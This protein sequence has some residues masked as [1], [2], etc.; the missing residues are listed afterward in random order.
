MI[1]DFEQEKLRRSDQEEACLDLL[2]GLLDPFL[3][4]EKADRESL[5]TSFFEGLNLGPRPLTHFVRAYYNNR[6]VAFIVDTI[7]SRAPLDVLST[8][9]DFVE[10]CWPQEKAM[11][12]RF[13]VILI[14]FGMKRLRF[15]ETGRLYECL[16]DYLLGR[17]D[18]LEVDVLQPASTVLEFPSSLRGN[19]DHSPLHFI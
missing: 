15:D 4:S 8:V 13:K 19:E 17:D 5:L 14:G 11:V 7:L 9:V 16:A 2:E 10:A 6:N 18:S 3:L 1:I 12:K